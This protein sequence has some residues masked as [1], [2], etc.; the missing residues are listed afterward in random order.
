PVAGPDH[1]GRHRPDADDA[2]QTSAK[3]AGD[4]SEA[5]EGRKEVADQAAHGVH[6]PLRHIGAAFG[7]YGGGSDRTDRHAFVELL[8]VRG[9]FANHQAACCAFSAASRSATVALFCMPSISATRLIVSAPARAKL[10]PPAPAMARSKACSAASTFFSAERSGRAGPSPPTAAS[11]REIRYACSASSIWRLR[12]LS[13]ARP[14]SRRFSS[15]RAWV[16]TASSFL[17]CASKSTWRE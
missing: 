14:S 4:S 9:W 1:E 6:A 8:P 12:A 15:S 11:R 13:A 16:W 3:A 17:A 10:T 5:P 7:D 2:W